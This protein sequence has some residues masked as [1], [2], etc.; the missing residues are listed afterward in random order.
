METNAVGVF[1]CAG[2]TA[3]ETAREDETAREEEL[4]I[5]YFAPC[6]QSQ[7]AALASCTRLG[8]S[9][10]AVVNHVVSFHAGRNAHDADGHCRLRRRGF[11][12]LDPVGNV[13]ALHSTLK[14]IQ[15]GQSA[16]AGV[17]A[18]FDVS[19]FEFACL[20]YGLLSGQVIDRKDV[21]L[22]VEF[23]G[24]IHCPCSPSFPLRI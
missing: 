9:V 12:P 16:V 3:V 18:E 1:A 10:F 22:F 2:R 21:R 15:F 24:I 19:R 14:I 5:G 23:Y 20:V 4:R 13:V 17:D 8:G 7:R 11:W 6:A